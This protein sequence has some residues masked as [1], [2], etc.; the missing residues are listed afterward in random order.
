[1]CGIVKWQ[2]LK[3]YVP[4]VEFEETSSLS[5]V[6]NVRLLFVSLNGAI[7]LK[8]MFVLGSLD[9]QISTASTVQ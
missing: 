8:M 6:R 7:V 1:M 2:Y 4:G 3:S 9:I 5:L